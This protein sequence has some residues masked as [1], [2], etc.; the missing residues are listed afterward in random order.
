MITP[1]LWWLQLQLPTSTCNIMYSPRHHMRNPTPLRM[2]P[3]TMHNTVFLGI[4]VIVQLLNNRPSLLP[5]YT[6]CV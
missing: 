1:Q 3:Y 5:L 6:D 4:T 2:I